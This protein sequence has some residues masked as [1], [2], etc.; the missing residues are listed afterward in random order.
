MKTLIIDDESNARDALKG[1]LNYNFP[2]IEITGE[3][4]GVFSGLKAIH[5][6]SPNLVFLDIRMG[7]GTGIDLLQRLEELNFSLIF[8]TAYDEYALKAFKYS[9]TDYL[10][11]PIDIDELTE[12]IE[13]VKK[14]MLHPGFDVQALIDNLKSDNTNEKKIVL[15]TSDSIHLIK[16]SSIVRCESS[17]NY[18]QFYFDNRKP[19]IVSKPLKDYEAILPASVFFRSHQSHLI[20]INKIDHIKKQDGFQI[21]MTDGSNVPVSTRKKETLLSLLEQI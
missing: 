6:L 8:L 1:M 20:N 2:E 18:T 19:V 16:I 7:D 14:N 12:A 13:K 9:A 3:A 11:K 15:K 5:D 21:I 17:G 4:D 10:L